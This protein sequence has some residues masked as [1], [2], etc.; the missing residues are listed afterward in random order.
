MTAHGGPALAEP[1][2][3]TARGTT[4]TVPAPERAPAPRP[5]PHD[6]PRPSAHGAPPPLRRGRRSPD[7]RR[8]AWIGL[9]A[10]VVLLVAGLLLPEGVLLGA[11]LILAG[12]AGHT[13]DRRRGDRRP[14]SR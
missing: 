3:R 1:E 5:S 7:R 12:A 9:A 11:A 8:P 4:R 2:D 14:A 13:L 6:G 10:A